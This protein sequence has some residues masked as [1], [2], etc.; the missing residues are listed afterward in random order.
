[1]RDPQPKPQQPFSVLCRWRCCSSAVGRETSAKAEAPPK[2]GFKLQTRKEAETQPI[3]GFVLF[4]ES[5]RDQATVVGWTVLTVVAP[6]QSERPIF[7]AT[8]PSFGCKVDGRT[9]ALRFSVH[10]FVAVVLCDDDA[11]SSSK[12]AASSSIR[13]RRRCCC[14]RRRRRSIPSRCQLLLLLDGRSCCATA[15]AVRRVTHEPLGRHS[16]PHNG[17]IRCNLPSS[18]K[19]P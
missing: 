2:S 19:Q 17:L 13:C 5:I 12:Q 14:L 16:S 11:A 7:H 9:A 6:L 15:A 10:A 8:E 4:H 1:M 18:Q 3:F